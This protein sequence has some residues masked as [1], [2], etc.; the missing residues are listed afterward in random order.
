M[1][2]KQD[3]IIGIYCKFAVNSD[4]EKLNQLIIDNL[5]VFN[6]A[7]IYTKRCLSSEVD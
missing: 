1:L 5:T 6:Y 4:W 7:R 3:E 2:I